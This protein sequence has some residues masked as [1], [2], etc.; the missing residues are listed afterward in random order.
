MREQVLKA[1]MDPEKLRDIII[2]LIVIGVVS[3]IIRNID[4]LIN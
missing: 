3:L 2:P 1:K 4:L